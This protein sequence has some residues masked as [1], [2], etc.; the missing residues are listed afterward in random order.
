[1]A[2][3]AEDYANMVLI[4]NYADLDG[5]VDLDEKVENVRF[6]DVAAWLEQGYDAGRRDLLAELGAETK[7]L[8]EQ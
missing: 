3:K 8:N 4:D 1:M 2:S 5:S 7:A 6:R